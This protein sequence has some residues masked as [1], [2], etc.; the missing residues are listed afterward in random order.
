[1]MSLTYMT[2]LHTSPNT[3]GSD[4]VTMRTGKILFSTRIYVVWKRP[5]MMK[6]MQKS[7]QWHCMLV[8]NSRRSDARYAIIQPPQQD[9]IHLE[10]GWTGRGHH[11]AC[12]RKGPAASQSF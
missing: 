8:T 12:Y 10:I 1:M 2:I 11:F 4:S 3:I 5:G 9:V 7:R 6:S